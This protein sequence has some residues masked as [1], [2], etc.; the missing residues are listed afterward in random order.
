MKYDCFLCRR[1]HDHD[2]Q[3]AGRELRHAVPVRLLSQLGP[4]LELQEEPHSQGNTHQPGRHCL[5]TGGVMPFQTITHSEKHVHFHEME[6]CLCLKPKII[7][8]SVWYLQ[9]SQ[10]Y[11]Y[12]LTFLFCVT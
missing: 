9:V 10:T 11:H 7:L 8:E 2:V 1:V 5:L 6:S 4:G 3:R 12:S